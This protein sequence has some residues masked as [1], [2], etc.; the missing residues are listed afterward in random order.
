MLPSRPAF[1]SSRA[2]AGAEKG[3]H[4]GRGEFPAHQRGV[5]GVLGPPLHPGVPGGLLAAFARLVRCDLH[6]RAGDRGPQPARGQPP[7]AVEHQRLGGAGFSRVQHRG[8]PGDDL[9]LGLAQGPVPERRPGPGQ[10]HLQ[11]MS[12]VQQALGGPAGLRQHRGQL[13][14]GE[15]VPPGRHLSRARRATARPGTPAD[16][17]RDRRVL[18]G[19]GVRLDAVPGA[20]HPGDFIVGGAVVPVILAGGPGGEP[21]QRPAPRHHIK[22]HPGGE[23]GRP[24]EVLPGRPP[25]G[26]GLARAAPPQG[27]RLPAGQA[28]PGGT[29]A[30]GGL[31]RGDPPALGDD[32]VQVVLPRPRQAIRVRFLIIGVRRLVLVPLGVTPGL[33]VLVGHPV[34]AGDRPEGLPG[35]VLVP[36]GTRRSRSLRHAPPR[37]GG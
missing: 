25:G 22:Q 24:A 15:L 29:G 23:P 30:R 14:H 36:P 9:H 4:L 16:Q 2:H 17:L 18:A 20:D 10:L 21:G 28:H 27:D 19:A 31:L 37:S 12:Q 1:F 8:G 32:L 3:Q 13:G 26:S 11:V 7:R 6:H 5:P 35:G 33:P 34:R